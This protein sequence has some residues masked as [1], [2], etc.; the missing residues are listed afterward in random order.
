MEP[1][2]DSR[3]GHR[4]AHAERL[5]GLHQ[6][7]QLGANGDATESGRLFFQAREGHRV[8]R[9]NRREKLCCNGIRAGSMPEHQLHALGVEAGPQ[10]LD[11]RAGEVFV[12]RPGD[13]H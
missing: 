6:A 1:L 5:R 2:L 7:I 9:W 8:R 12:D 4:E 3:Q 10:D 13:Q 11:R